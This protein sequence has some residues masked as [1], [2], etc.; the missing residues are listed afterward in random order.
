MTLFSPAFST[1]ESV[2][3]QDVL[4]P[5]KAQKDRAQMNF[6]KGLRQKHNYLNYTAHKK[7]T[8]NKNS[9]HACLSLFIYL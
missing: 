4:T 5:E 6:E 2:H 9:V 7:K 3:T 8:F 1:Y